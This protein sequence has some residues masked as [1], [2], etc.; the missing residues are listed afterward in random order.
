MQLTAI[1]TI[2][3]T[4]ELLSG[5]H[6]GAGDN[7]MHIGGTDNPVITH[8]YT[9]QPYIP[10]SS[11]KGKLRSLLEW[12]SGA[13]QEKVLGIDALEK[14]RSGGKPGQ[15]Q[16]VQHILQLFG[17]GGGDS[18]EQAAKELGPTRLSFWDCNI[19]ES[20]IKRI[21][22]DKQLFTE[23]K[24]ENMINRISGVAEHPRNT[25]R[26]PAGVEF[27][28]RVQLKV[29]DGDAPQLIDTLLAALKLLELDSLGGA[30]S[31]GY[32]KVRFNGLTLN[33]ESLQQRFDAIKP[34]DLAA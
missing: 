30:G 13:V 32:G 22:D 27:R 25:E 6:I 7:E 19:T 21:D 26:V 12:R 3:A 29:L 34:F 15:A 17:I 1:H 24:S 10:G 8:P 23:V 16:A 20:W 4:L 11:I 31:R 18:Q 5:L 28:F 33:G 9:R 2:E 14:A